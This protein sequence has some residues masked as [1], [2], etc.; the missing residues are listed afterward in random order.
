MGSFRFGRRSK[1]IKGRLFRKASEVCGES[2]NEL[3]RSPDVPGLGVVLH[4]GVG[5]EPEDGI[6]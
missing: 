6:Q 2:V 3:I 5:R 1:A 4:S